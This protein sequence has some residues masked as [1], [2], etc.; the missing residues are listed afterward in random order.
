MKRNWV[1]RDKRYLDDH[2]PW[3]EGGKSMESV[4]KAARR[5]FYKSQTKK[6]L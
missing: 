6:E 3:L 1:L 2:H 4:K 5:M